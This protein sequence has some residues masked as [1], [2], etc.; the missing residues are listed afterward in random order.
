M[1]LLGEQVV[2]GAGLA[3]ELEG[4]RVEAGHD[5]VALA[6][7]RGDVRSGDC[8]GLASADRRDMAD[9]TWQMRLSASRL[10]L[11]QRLAQ[12]TDRA[13]HIPKICCHVAYKSITAAILGN[14][15][16]TRRLLTSCKP[17]GMLQVL[18]IHYWQ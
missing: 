12:Q 9:C 2:V 3:H 1:A 13:V 6:A 14:G 5:G 16:T 15:M 8:R 17:R 10:P 4:A 18:H 11:M 7:G